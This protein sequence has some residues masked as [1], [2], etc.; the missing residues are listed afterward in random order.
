M[1]KKEKQGKHDLKERETR[2]RLGTGGEHSEHRTPALEMDLLANLRH[3]NPC[4]DLSGRLGGS[5]GEIPRCL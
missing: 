4:P 3:P 2:K 1:R 5:F